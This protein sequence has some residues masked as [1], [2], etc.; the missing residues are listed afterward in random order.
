MKSLNKQD[1]TDSIKNYLYPKS[2]IDFAYIFGSYLQTDYYHDI[3][4]AVY[5][6]NGFDYKNLNLYP[7]GYAS[8]LSGELSKIIKTDKIDVVIMNDAGL[9]ILHR[10]MN[11]GFLLFDRDTFSRIYFENQ[12]RKEYI[13]A[14]H[15]RKIKDIYIKAKIY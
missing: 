3:D 5:I 6:K 4:I 10:I 8:L 2:E 14:G 7:F 13:D 15:L 11:K 1:I 12:T 9:L